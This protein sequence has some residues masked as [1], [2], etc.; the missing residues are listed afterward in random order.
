MENHV[1]QILRLLRDQQLEIK[2]RYKAEV[3]G[4]FG[5][6]ARGE[7]QRESDLDLLVDFDEE[8]DLFDYVGLSQYL[9]EK[10]KRKIDLVPRRSL[11]EEIKAKVLEEA[12]YTS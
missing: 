6:V 12:I 2:Q 4:L 10:L 11:R 3:K 7:A 1:E 9:E 5:S 8:A